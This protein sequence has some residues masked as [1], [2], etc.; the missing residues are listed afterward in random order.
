METF[1]FYLNDPFVF[2][3]IK[4]FTSI[5][6]DISEDGTDKIFLSI[7]NAETDT[8]KRNIKKVFKELLLT[9]GFIYDK[10]SGILN[11]K[12]KDEDFTKFL[13]IPTNFFRMM[14]FF[15]D[16]GYVFYHCLLSFI[17]C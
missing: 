5:F 7:K 13:S 6:P 16:I 4:D 3:I 10:D 12:L 8:I 2:D 11:V 17:F 1:S 14:D 9:I 15:N